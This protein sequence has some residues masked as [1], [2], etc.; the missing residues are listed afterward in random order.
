MDK[1]KDVLGNARIPL[2]RGTL[3]LLKLG[4]DTV[5]GVILEVNQEI[6]CIEPFGMMPE[7]AQGES[8]TLASVAFGTLSTELVELRA[9]SICVHRPPATQLWFHERR[10][11]RRMPVELPA[12]LSLDGTR[13]LLGTTADLSLGGAAIQFADAPRR[14]TP[15]DRA[16]VT[17]TLDE[18][19]MIAR[20]ILR[21][22]VR[23]ED[24]DGNTLGVLVGLQFE[25]MSSFARNALARRLEAF[26][27]AM[28]K[29][30]Q[31][32]R[33]AHSDAMRY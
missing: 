11:Y 15:G 16:E 18:G 24:E 13:V 3:V 33:H 30:A 1:V 21:S 32:V 17:L 6:L 2:R 29:R 27:A 4:S 25:A 23:K 8:I 31:Q 28:D 22:V 20:C 12:R 19:P 26:V 5:E 7:V 9:H 10:Q 14:M